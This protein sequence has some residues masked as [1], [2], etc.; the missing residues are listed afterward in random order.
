MRARSFVGLS[1]LFAGVSFAGPFA[2]ATGNVTSTGSGGSG[3]SGSTSTST[4]SSSG[5]QASSSSSGTPGP[6]TTGAECAALTDACNTG[7]CINGMCGKL[8]ANDG[9]PCDDGKQCTLNTTCDNGVC[10]GGTL[11]PCNSQTPCMVGKCDVATDA[12][13]EVPGNDGS[14]CVDDNACTLTGSCTNGQCIAGGMVDCS[15]LDGECSQ[16]YCDPQIGCKVMP[17]NDGTP[18]NDGFFCTINDTCN[19]GMCA[20]VPNPCTPPGS[21]ICMIGSCNEATDKCTSVP[22]NNGAACDDGNLCTSGETC[23]NGSCLGGVPANNGVA[24]DDGNGCTGGTTCSNGQCVNPTSQIVACN[25]GDQC[26]PAGCAA[27]GDPDCLYYQPGVQQN[28]PVANLTGWTQCFIDFY[29]DYNTPMQTIL[30]QCNK[31]KLLIACRPTGAQSLTLAAMGPRADVL[32]DCGQTQDCTKQSNGVGF[33]YSDN[34]SWGFAQGGDA[35]NRFSCDY[36]N[37]NQNNTNL[38]MCWHSG[39]GFINGGYRC[40]DNYPFGSDWERIVYHAD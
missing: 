15:F 22:G 40:G 28:L 21:D 30:T 25:A 37:G 38:R 12:C 20:G 39:G 3:G 6:C 1:L 19:N 17:L 34:W 33:Y 32:Y 24:C 9:V 31:A 13:I 27:M 5:N 23:S 35:V 11:K 2:C 14:P 26:C 7:A 4:S 29:D 36:D 10:Q 18:C 8:A 16:G